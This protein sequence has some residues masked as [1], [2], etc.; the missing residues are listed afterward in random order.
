MFAIHGRHFQLQFL[1]FPLPDIF[2]LLF[3]NMHFDSLFLLILD[4]EDVLIIVFAACSPNEDFVF[5]WGCLCFCYFGEDEGFSGGFAGVVD[6]AD[7][8]LFAHLGFI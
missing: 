7:H 4:L 5:G 1:T 2:Q 8:L 6:A 3:L